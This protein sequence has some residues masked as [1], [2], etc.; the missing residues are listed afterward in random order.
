MSAFGSHNSEASTSTNFLLGT[1]SSH[2]NSSKYRAYASA[3]DKALKSFESTTEWADLIAALG[4]LGKVFASNSKSFN[5]IPNPLTVAKRLSQCLHPA[6]PSGVHLKALETYRQVFNILGHSGHNQNLARSL[7]LYAIGLF[8]LIDHC[9]IKVKSELLSIFE[10]YLLPLGTHIRPALPGFITAVLLALEEGTE[11]YGRAFQ[12]LDQLL[13]KVGTAAF[14]TCFWQAVGG[15][16]SVRLPALIFINAKLEKRKSTQPAAELLHTLAGG[17]EAAASVTVAECHQQQQH[18]LRALC[19]VAEDAG[20]TSALAQRHLLDFLCSAIPL[21]SAWLPRAELIQLLRRCMFVVLRRDMSLNRRLYQWL[22][23]RSNDVAFAGL[24]V[25]GTEDSMDLAFFKQYTLPLI[26]S[27]IREYLHCADTVEVPPLSTGTIRRY[28]TLLKDPQIQFP[29]VRVC[30]LLHY[31][32]D[33]PELGQMVLEESLADLLETV[34]ARD[35]ELVHDLQ[36]ECAKFEPNFEHIW[37]VHTMTMDDEQRNRRTDEIKKNFNVL[38]NSLEPGFVWNFFK[39]T[40]ASS[41]PQQDSNR[42]Q[43]GEADVGTPPSSAVSSPLFFPLMV[44]FCVRNVQLDSHGDIRGRHLPL[45][46][47]SVLSGMATNFTNDQKQQQLSMTDCWSMLAN[48]VSCRRLLAE[49]TQNNLSMVFEQ[50]HDDA[51]DGSP[52]KK[53]IKC[54]EELAEEQKLV[55]RCLAACLRLLAVLCD[56]YCAARERRLFGVLVALFAL[57]RDFADF[58]FYSLQLLHQDNICRSLTDSVLLHTDNEPNQHQQQSQQQMPTWLCSVLRLIDPPSWSSCTA[59]FDF[60]LRNQLFDL[61]LY[62]C[63]RSASMLEQHSAVFGR[64]QSQRRFAGQQQ[65]QE[66]YQQNQQPKQKTTTTVL[67]KPFLSMADLQRIDQEALCQKAAAVLWRRFADDDGTGMD[68]AADTLLHPIALLLLRLHSRRVSETSSEVED[69]VVAELTSSNKVLSGSAVRKFHDLWVFCRSAVIEEVY[70][71]ILLKPMNRV[72]MVLLSFIADDKLS[73]EQVE[74]KALAYAWFLD[75]AHHNELHKIVQMLTLMLLNPVTARVSIQFVQMQKR[76]TRD[77]LPSMPAEANCVALTTVSGKQTFHHV[78]TDVEQQ[79]RHCGSGGV[80]EQMRNSVS[81]NKSGN[82]WYNYSFVDCDP[83]MAWVSDLNKYLLLGGTNCNS[84]VSSGAGE[85]SFSSAFTSGGTCFNTPLQQQQQHGHVFNNTRNLSSPPPN[86]GGGGLGMFMMAQQQLQHNNQSP[87]P[88]IASPSIVIGASGG[89]VTNNTT[90]TSASSAK[91]H[92]RTVSDIPQFDDDAESVDAYSMDT[93]MLDSDVVETV[94]YL[95]DSVCDIDG[96]EKE[97][98]EDESKQGIVEGDEDTDELEELATNMLDQ[99][100]LDESESLS[101]MTGTRQH[102]T[103][104]KCK[105]SGDKA[106]KETMF[107]RSARSAD[108]RKRVASSTTRDSTY[109]QTSL[110]GS[111]LGPGDAAAAM[112]RITSYAGGDTIR[113]IRTGHRRQDSLQESIFSTGT[114]ELRLFDPTELPN[115]TCPGDHK[116]PLLDETFSHMLF[117]AESPSIVDLGRAEKLFRTM[118][119]LLRSGNG[120]GRH[121]VNSMLFTNMSELINRT[122]TTSSGKAGGGNLS[123]IGTNS[124]NNS[125]ATIGGAS[126]AATQQLLDFM[127]RHYQHIQGDGFWCTETAQDQQ[128]NTSVSVQKKEDGIAGGGGG[129]TAAVTA[130]T[131]SESKAGQQQRHSTLFEI[132]S[133]VVLYF[134]R[135]YYLNSPINHVSETDLVLSWKCKIAALDCFT[136]LLHILDD[137]VR[138]ASSKELATFVQQIYRQTKTQKVILTLMLAAIPTPPNQ[139]GWRMPLSMDIAEF[140]NGP[141]HS[142]HFRDLIF[143]YHRSL[144]SLASALVVLEYSLHVG[145]RH[146]S[147]Q[148]HLLALP[149]NRNASPSSQIT[150]NQINYNSSQNRSTIREARYSVVE[151]RLFLGVILN[152]LKRC[153]ARHEL[154]LHFLVGI[155]PYLDRALATFVV[156]TVEQICRNLYECVFINGSTASVAGLNSA[157]LALVSNSQQPSVMEHPKNPIQF[158]DYRVGRANDVATTV[159]DDGTMPTVVYPANYILNLLESLMSIMH[160]CLLD[161]RNASMLSPFLASTKHS[162]LSALAY[163]FAT[164]NFN[165]QSSTSSTAPMA[166]SMTPLRSSS[167]ALAAS[168]MGAGGGGGG[169]TFSSSNMTSMVGTAISVIPGTGLINNLFGRVFTSGENP[170]NIASRTDASGKSAEM[171]EAQRELIKRFPSALAILIDVW[172]FTEQQRKGG[173][174]ALG[175][176]CSTNTSTPKVG[177]FRSLSTLILDILNPVAK[178]HKN[179]LI[180]SLGV[181]WMFRNSYGGGAK[182]ADTCRCSFDYS[183]QQIEVANLAL[184]LNALSLTSIICSVSDT[185]KESANKTTKSSSSSASSVNTSEKLGVGG[186]SLEVALL[187]LLHQCTRQVTVTE[188][189]ESWAALAILFND[190]PLAQLPARASF[191]EFAMLTDFVRRCGSQSIIEDKQISKT[192]LE[193]CQKLIDAINVIVGWQLESTTWLKRTL[194]VRQDASSSQKT[195]PSSDLSPVLEQRSGAGGSVLGGVSSVGGASTAATAQFFSSASALASEANSMRGSTVSLTGAGLGGAGS[196]TAA[197]SAHAPPSRLSAPLD[198]QSLTASS[199]GGVGAGGTASGGG[200]VL[201]STTSAGGGAA[202]SA[203]SVLRSSIKDSSGGAANKKDPSDSTQALFLLAENLAEL[204]DSVCKSEDKEKLLPALQ[205]VWNNTLPYLKAKSAKNVRFFLASSQFLASMS[206]YNYMRS[207][208]KKNAMDLLWD[209]SF[210]KMDIHALRQ[211]LIVIDN[212]MTNDKTSFKELLTRITTSTSTTLSTLIT[213]KEQ[214]YE[215]RAQYLKRLAFVI[216]SSEL[217]QYAGQ[218]NEIQERLTENL[219]LCQVPVIHT[220][221]FTCYRVLLVRMSPSSFVSIWPSM[222]TELVHVL[223]QI[224]HQLT[225]TTPTSSS[226]GASSVDE[227]KSARDEQCMQLFLAACKLLETLCTLPSGYMSQFQMCRWTFISPMNAVSVSDIFVPY[228]VRLNQLLNKRYTELTGADIEMR[229]ASLFNIKTLTSYQELHPFFHALTMQNGTGQKQRHICNGQM[230]DRSSTI[231]NG[232]GADTGERE[233]DEFGNDRSNSERKKKIMAPRLR[234]AELLNGSHSLKSAVARIEHSLY[235]DFAEHWQL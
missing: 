121:L 203:A 15:S 22:L 138:E 119:T 155:L 21:D 179:A 60:V 217:D 120:L 46:L 207:V 42:Q 164:P 185:L 8:P 63:V 134:F 209:N 14:Y 31:M 150:E 7:F 59:G 163:P 33:R 170:S 131:S 32:L 221:V 102:S 93:S 228:T 75:C 143:A 99:A 109:D 153:P 89:N 19:A 129:G 49:I 47:H 30:R 9:G 117:Y 206:S 230:D 205:A 145:T 211:W 20:S 156:H 107:N 81:S 112:P 17:G 114:Q 12:L 227:Q 180:N 29:E 116:Q 139:K 200:R 193:V 56:W 28:G 104:G 74:L 84:S 78:C 154:W 162:V 127:A 83:R 218:L 195:L 194:V 123:N 184:N 146:F 133:T 101:T 38:L 198:T 55:E 71:G 110:V 159:G 23:N 90:V 48:I 215:M 106:E 192:I 61:L 151:L 225:S 144:L 140:N 57:M 72:V 82:S 39:K 142:K 168:A 174:T 226:G 175:S 115:S 118:G 34:C 233:E 224:D 223:A 202:S 67:L 229:S 161:V 36:G 92:R 173:A 135:S 125:M 210:F 187:E 108:K 130:S 191:L 182:M 213:S 77:H 16:S 103:R 10:Q 186:F 79:R 13:D 147:S 183:A 69:I 37:T 87:V 5:D 58:P 6:L 52:T 169:G 177:T 141:P 27:A 96:D 18:M 166:G 65:Q 11:F 94:Q 80:R 235:V 45:L 70:A 86:C 197:A 167:S 97:E 88:S 132:F 51:F 234:D 68:I 3:V 157:A 100:L 50:I 149:I 24:P 126:T 98:E 220:Q 212:L 214:E 190:S 111:L 165:R 62:M 54:N 2:Q 40:F 172:A 188:L 85:F 1:F 160:F 219:R 4:K 53:G 208:W 43:N 25:N 178:R 231:S 95:V 176:F 113:R 201:P 148:T 91:G 66:H 199:C 216:L 41:F 122:G 124:A 171:L 204:I 64:A 189:R 232:V 44:A 105:S 181:V 152:A 196:G 73:A 136:E 26:K 128:N 137:T 35:A 158:V 222:V 76:V